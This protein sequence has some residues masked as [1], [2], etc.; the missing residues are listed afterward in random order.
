MAAARINPFY[1]SANEEKIRKGIAR[2]G[3]VL[4]KFV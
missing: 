2:L 1:G 4:K 3:K